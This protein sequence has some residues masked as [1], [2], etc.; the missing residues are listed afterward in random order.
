MLR[1]LGIQKVIMAIQP[2]MIEP[3]ELKTVRTRS[4]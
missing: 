1:N 4:R 3:L 2:I